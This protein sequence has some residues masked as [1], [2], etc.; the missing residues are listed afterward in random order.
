MDDN[1]HKFE[2]KYFFMSA[3]MN[4]RYSLLWFPSSIVA[5]LFSLLF[6][7]NNDI[8]FL[9][10]KIAIISL[11][12]VAKSFSVL[13]FMND[14]SV[15]GIML[16]VITVDLIIAI[17]LL[18]FNVLIAFPIIVITLWI[19]YIFSRAYILTNVLKDMDKTY[20]ELIDDTKD[21]LESLNNANNN[22]DDDIDGDD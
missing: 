5:A 13:K 20:Q 2:W 15:M 3:K 19:I 17:G 1:K 10:I 7:T 16:L 22:Y 18:F 9:Y 12:L 4:F 8:V 6:F 21:I 11:I 14:T